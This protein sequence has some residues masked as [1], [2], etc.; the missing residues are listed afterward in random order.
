MLAFNCYIAALFFFLM[1]KDFAAINIATIII[2][3]RN[4][5]T[6]AS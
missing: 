4:T 1:N 6:E 5:I 3:A 2:T